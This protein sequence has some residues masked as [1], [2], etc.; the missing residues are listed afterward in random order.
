MT[1]VGLAR[2]SFARVLLAVRRA[3]LA[4]ERSPKCF[5]EA[6]LGLDPRDSVTVMTTDA[7]FLG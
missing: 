3:V 7:P 2:R 6:W 5:A 1:E 4:M